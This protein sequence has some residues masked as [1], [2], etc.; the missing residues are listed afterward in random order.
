Q[1]TRYIAATDKIDEAQ[2]ALPDD[3]PSLKPRTLARCYRA[4]VRSGANPEEK[5]PWSE[6]AE[7][8]Y[9]AAIDAA[10]KNMDLYREAAEYFM[11]AGQLDKA[12]TLI[13]VILD[14][15]TG[16]SR[17]ARQW[18]E[19]S[20]AIV[21]ASGGSIDDL[22][23]AL[24]MLRSAD[25][26]TDEQRAYNIRLQLQVLARRNRVADRP[27]ML[28][29][30]EQLRSVV[31]NRLTTKE[32]L[33]LASLY[34]FTGQWPSAEA[35]Y[36]DLLNSNRPDAHA[37]DPI[38]IASYAMAM[39]RQQEPLDDERV[40]KLNGFV[41]ELQRIAPGT[42]ETV[43]VQARLLH[44]QGRSDETV[45]VLLTYL[46]RLT[47][48]PPQESLREMVEQKDV[49]GAI[50][51]LREILR[52]Q[53]DA[54]LAQ[55]VPQLEDL[56]RQQKTDEVLGVLQRY[57]SAADM[58]AGAQVQMHR[59][60]AEWL[61]GF[62]QY[63]AAEDLF[64]KYIAR[65]RE[66]AEASLALVGFFGR[67]GRID[68]GLETCEKVW[69][70]LADPARAAENS[71][72]LIRQKSASEQQIA[73]V[74]KML[75][76]A[77]KRT[78]NAQ[79]R[80]QYQIF[81]AD[82][83]DV[84]RRAPEAIK[85]YEGIL[86]VNDRHV[87]ALNNLA[88]LLAFQSGRESQAL[89]LINRA[90]EI[91][92]PMPALRD[93]RAVVLLRLQRPQDAISDLQEAL[94]QAGD[95]ASLWFHMAQARHQAGDRPGASDALRNAEAKGLSQTNLHRL[96]H[97]GLKALQSELSDRSGGLATGKEHP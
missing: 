83:R 29:L 7:R 68:E 77:A 38:V 90:I 34:D 49:E 15:S 32:R 27:E 64:R 78:D 67:Q 18:A 52:T 40:E 58:I 70:K 16:A 59:V 10:P 71:V 31:G 51:L 80:G 93:T 55:I 65:S 26:N 42:L 6:Q 4:L 41:E 66:P 96:E 20:Q 14:P 62:G 46:D 1:R 74:E 81:M 47:F 43:Q 8:Y 97:A 24:Q 91:A 36:K 82:L 57:I 76:D 48:N 56:L 33:Q 11:E 37:A 72:A 88:W 9:T 44:A 13:A 87:V 12:R 23:Q 19:H 53:K 79:L 92:G 25:L 86:A 89:A 60:V 30:L 17:E 39:L 22:T 54:A 21:K 73:R 50:E 61:E 95:D 69:N 45:P 94:E 28:K 85:I 63:A 75:I 2:Q 35:E 3:P 5:K 84:Q